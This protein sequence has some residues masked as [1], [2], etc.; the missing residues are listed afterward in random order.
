MYSMLDVDQE[1]DTYNLPIS[2]EAM[3]IVVCG[4][5]SEPSV[6]AST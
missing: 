5:K 3:H 1:E 6:F 2:A 4:C